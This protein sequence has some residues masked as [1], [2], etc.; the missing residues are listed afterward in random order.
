[1]SNS[2]SEQSVVEINQKKDSMTLMNLLQSHIL[3]RLNQNVMKNLPKK[4]EIV[5]PIDLTERQK[6]IYKSIFRRNFGA[7]NLLD[8]SIKTRGKVMLKSANKV[9]ML[10]R[11]C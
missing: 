6:E 2:E 9:L 3:N 1:M 4:K 7:L 11:L 5:I 10:L 8:K